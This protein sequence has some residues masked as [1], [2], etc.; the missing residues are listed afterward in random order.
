[1]ILIPRDVCV[2]LDQA[3]D[4]EWLVANG[5][6]G[7]ASSTIVGINTRRYHGLLVAAL[8]PPVRRT[9]L[10]ANINEE[11]EIDERTYYL[12]ANEY[13][14]DKIHPGGFV[15][16]EEFGI[17]N[18]IPSTLFRMGDNLLRKTVWMEHGHNTTYVRYSYLEG[19]DEC[20]LVLHPLCN[21]RDHHE[22]TRGVF[23]WDFGVE[24]VEGGCKITAYPDSDPFWISTYP[25]AEFTHTGVW[26]W[27]FVYRREVERGYT[28]KEDL[29]LPGVIRVVLRQGEEA[30][31]MASTEPP[32]ETAPLVEDAFEREEERQRAL[33]IRAGLNVEADKED[34]ASPNASEE[35]F[36][37]QLVL[38]ADT[39]I[40][41]RT[42]EMEGE[43]EGTTLDV[44]TVIAGYHWFTDWGRDTMIAI[45]G[46]MLA[47]GRADEAEE[48][49][50]AF[51]LFLRDGLLPNNFPDKGSTPHYNTVDATLW[52]FVALERLWQAT[53]SPQVA[54]DLYPLLVEVINK[55]LSGTLYGIGVDPQDGL[56]R[57]GEKGVQLTWMD[58]KVD[59]WV[60]TPRIGKPV[61]VNALWIAALR[62]M[63]RLGSN[64][65]RGG[66]K[67]KVP[68]FGALAKKAE[69][70]FRERFWYEGGSYLY[71][72]VDG[73]GGDDT[74]LRP[75]QIIAL[76]VP[77]LMPH[78]QARQALSAVREQ[79]FT[80]YGLRTLPPDD[81][82]YVGTYE[83]TRRERDAAYHNGTVWAWLLGPYFDAVAAIEGEVAARAEFQALLP[84]IRPHLA[85]AGLGSISEIFDA[86]SPQ[87]PKGCISQAWSV[88]E[89]LRWAQPFGSDE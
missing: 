10:L 59:D 27:N 2:D 81:P 85:E 79:L 80:P 38:A 63:E 11:A 50:R 56:L 52:M 89:L 37:A 83:G 68:D 20:C 14:D 47:T 72:V 5:I 8:E 41:E 12:A 35:A 87:S 54:Q 61:E 70:S 21:Y 29:Y 4:K 53:G 18:G 6:G 74:S 69:H 45:P 48:V 30:I 46:L 42:I 73:P 36:V 62:L 25:P 9:V 23:D 58:A 31:L 39:F 88:A 26:Y 44:P 32:E 33:L 66:K 82:N 22:I 34:A 3:L 76:A 86:D 49:L 7:Y 57:A 77:D 13:A 40:V 24:T 19:A 28:D 1:M 78:D 75:N 17:R 71:D 60:V 84:Q 67:S 16:I 55:H 15:H 43:K 65:A 51:A 64:T